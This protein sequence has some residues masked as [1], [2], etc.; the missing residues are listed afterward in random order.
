MG[1]KEDGEG[2]LGDR[3]RSRATAFL[4]V[5][6]RNHRVEAAAYDRQ[7]VVRRLPHA[8]RSASSTK[9]RISSALSCM[10]AEGHSLGEAGFHNPIVPR[11][12]Q[13]TVQ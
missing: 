1:V 6:L 3:P 9:Q 2:S 12:P 10:M 7:L 5:R 11:V 13:G 8:A 4:L